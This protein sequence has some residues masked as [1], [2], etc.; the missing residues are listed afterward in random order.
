MEIKDYISKDVVIITP[1]S[2]KKKILIESSFCHKIKAKIYTAEEFLKKYIGFYKNESL[3][4]IVKVF[5]FEPFYADLLLQNINLI[6]SSCENIEKVLLLKQVKCYLDEH[7]FF[8]KDALFSKYIQNKEVIIYSYLKEEPII[9]KIL[10]SF[11]SKQHF[12]LIEEEEIIKKI[13]VVKQETIEDEVV[14]TACFIVQLLSKGIMPS[15]IYISCLNPEYNSVIHRIFTQF[16]IPYYANKGQKLINFDMTKYFLELLEENE[17]TEALLILSESY[18][19]TQPIYKSLYQRISNTVSP[20][21]EK[22]VDSILL[23]VFRYLFKREEVKFS[24]EEVGI[25]NTDLLTTFFTEKDY[26]FAL[27]FMNDCYPRRYK[28]NAFFSD[29]EKEKLGIATSFIKNNIEKKKVYR[30]LCHIKNI[31]ISYSLKSPFREYTRSSFLDELDE[32]KILKEYIPSYSYISNDYN[33]YLLSKNLDLYMK[34]GEESEEL[35]FLL[36]HYKPLYQSYH[37]QYKKISIVSLHDYLKRQLTLSYTSLDLFFRC[38]FRYYINQILNVDEY[39]E[40]T[41]SQ[42]IGNIVHHILYRVLNEVD[43]PYERIIDEEILPYMEIGDAKEKFFFKKYKKEILKIIYIIIKQRERTDFKELYLEKK[44][45]SFLESEISITIKGFIDKVLF[46]Q[47][48]SGKRY[49]IVIDY[50]TGNIHMNLASMVYG[51]GMQLPIY[52]YLLKKTDPTYTFAGFYY[53]NIMKEIL[54]YKQG[55]QYSEQLQDAYRLDGYTFKNTALVSHIDKIVENSYI[56]GLK[57]QKNGDFY[58]YTK[59]LSANEVDML[60][61]ITEDNINKACKEIEGANFRIAPIKIGMETEITG[62]SFCKYHDICFKRSDDIVFVKEHKNLD[63]LRG[64][65]V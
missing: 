63:F 11:S 52:L 13:Q 4:E 25:C 34:F 6:D 59:V 51:I 38:P 41:L 9:Q 57:L 16:K 42:K 46:F 29:N 18:S 28:D 1:Y 32:R 17:I 33:Q 65:K 2:C 15:H 24:K 53:Q 40:S 5:S 45:S 47:N 50:K 62:C 60:L 37:N 7:G 56:K 55:K 35:S 64:E 39:G 26:V 54:P 20:Y 31:T 22:K 19:L 36:T 8:E 12:I 10:S 44:F 58:A 49:I 3:Y 61:T 23:Q 21:L 30:K 48:E 27:G 43:Q 14:M